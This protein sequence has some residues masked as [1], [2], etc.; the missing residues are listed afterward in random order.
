MIMGGGGGGSVPNVVFK[1]NSYFT[2][3]LKLFWS[4]ATRKATNHFR[5]GP[6]S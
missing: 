5:K 4:R 3:F 1:K 2:Y 6:V